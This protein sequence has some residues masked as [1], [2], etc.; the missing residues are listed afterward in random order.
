[1]RIVL[2]ACPWLQVRCW[3]RAL[4]SHCRNQP[5]PCRRG[6]SNDPVC[7]TTSAELVVPIR[8][9]G[10]LPLPPRPAELHVI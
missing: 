9:V 3:P 5:H 4:P 10:A 2:G 8:I 6:R 7:N 1:M